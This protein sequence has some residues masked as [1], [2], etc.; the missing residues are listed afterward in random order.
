MTL[1]FAFDF[2]NPDYAQ[3]F[4]WRAER[5]ERLRAKPELL[6]ALLA[7]YRDNPAQMIIDWGC[8]FDPRNAERGLPPIIPFILFPKQIEWVDW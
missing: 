7:H 5:L 4:A 2:R 1:P 6:P 3:V 8:T